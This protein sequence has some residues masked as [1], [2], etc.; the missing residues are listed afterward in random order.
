[1][2]QFTVRKQVSIKAPATAVWDA[3]TNP[4]KTKHYFFGCKVFSDWKPGSDIVFK[5][6]MF[7]IIPI[8]MQGKI[9]HA[10]PARLLQYTLYNKGGSQSQVTDQLEE[11][12]GLTTLTIT[13]NVGDGEGAESRYAR[14]QKGWDKILSGLKKFVEGS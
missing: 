11:S 2:S 4:E 7:W 9:I 1:M 6:R 3:L 12:N 5:G 8:R 10:Q 13:D 14:S